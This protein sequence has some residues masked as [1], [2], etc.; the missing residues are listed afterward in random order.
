MPNG[1]SDCC[2]TCWHNAKNKGEAGYEHA[3]DPGPDFCTIRGLE[4]E[5]PFWTYCTNHPHHD[6]SRDGIP[7]GPVWKHD[8]VGRVVWQLSPDDEQTRQHILRLAAEIIEQPQE[9][10]PL[11]L[12]RDEVIV[13]QLGEWRESRAVPVLERI[14]AFDPSVATR[15]P[16]RRTRETLVTAAE[17]ALRKIRGS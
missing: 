6:P 12:Y 14:V 10:Y 5:N 2:G 15:G 9:E 13:W 1:G 11:G 16:L 7:V 3:G 8:G 4:M 17:G